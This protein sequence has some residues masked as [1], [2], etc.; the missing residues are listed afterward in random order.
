MLQSYSQIFI[1]KH[2]E[3][4]LVELIEP[5]MAKLVLFLAWWQSLQTS[6]EVAWITKLYKYE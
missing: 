3:W 5:L 1:V 4:N 2:I 6:K